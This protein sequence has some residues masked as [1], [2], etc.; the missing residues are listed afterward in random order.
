METASQKLDGLVPDLRLSTKHRCAARCT[1]IDRQGRADSALP[2]TP[3][4]DRPRGGTQCF[5]AGSATQSGSSKY[6]P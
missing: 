2:G 1:P 5:I 6:V 3:D 4:G